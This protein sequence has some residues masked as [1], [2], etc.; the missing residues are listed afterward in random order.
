MDK[1]KLTV[2]VS[3]QF[4]DDMKNIFHYGIETFGYVSAVK[5]NENIEKLVNNLGIGYYMYPECRFL[6]TKS[7]MYRN[8]ILESYLIIYRVTTIRVEVLRVF[9]S[10]ICAS[11]R[12]RLVRKISM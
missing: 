9:H 7:K 6:A 2:V 5:F 4:H 12:I 1:G 11:G 3:E 10:S 8:I